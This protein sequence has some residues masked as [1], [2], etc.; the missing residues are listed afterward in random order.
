MQSISANHHI[1][2]V[3]GLK[4]EFSVIDLTHNDQSIRKWELF[5]N[6]EILKII[7]FKDNQYLVVT[8]EL[9]LYLATL[10]NG[11]FKIDNCILGFND[12]II[13]ARFN[14][15]LKLKQEFHFEKEQIV[16]ITNSCYIKLMDLPSKK[17][18]ALIGH[19]DIIM[20]MDFQN[21]YLITGSKDKLIKLWKVTLY[22]LE[23]VCTF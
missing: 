10:E 6:Q 22:N 15:Q 20:C 5:E 8:S 4:G 1:L 19:E 2:L 17:V 9:H 7:P 3:G 14:K 13:D 18:V 11:N 23:L 21:N 16:F 12:E